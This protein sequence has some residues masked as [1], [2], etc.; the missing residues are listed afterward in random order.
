M[1]LVDISRAERPTLYNHRKMVRFRKVI[2][3]N[4]LDTS[5]YIG[6]ADA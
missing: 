2:T 5:A 4:G 6:Q 1:A 3:G